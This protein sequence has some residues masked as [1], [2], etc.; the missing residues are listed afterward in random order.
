MATYRPE[1]MKKYL[2]L[3]QPDDAVFCTYVFIDGT[4]ENVRAKTRTLDFEPK[5]PEECPEWTFCALAS[6]QWPDAGPKSEAYLSP[7]ALFRDPFFK[8]RNK[9]VLCEVLQTDRSPNKT[10]TRRSCL[11]AMNKAKDQQPWFGIEQEYVVTEKDGHP[12]DWPRDVK[13]TI[14]PLGPYCFGVGADATSGRYISDAHYKACTYAGVKMAGTNCEGMLSQW[15]YQVGPLEGVDAADH[16][17][18]SRYILDR[19]AEDFGVLVTLDPMPYPPGDWLGSAMHTNFSTKAMRSDGG[20]SAIRTAIEKLKRNA[21]ADLAKYDT[22]RIKRNQLRV[23]SGVMATPLKQ[24][25]ADECSKE[26]SVRIP[27]AVVDAGKGY[28]EDRRPGANADPYTVCETII[29]TPDDV[30]FCTYVFIDGTLEN[31]RAKTRTL[32]F[33]PKTPEECPRWTFCALGTYQWGDASAKSEMY[34]E[35]VALF[36]DPFLKGRNKL[37]LCQ[38][39]KYDGTPHETNTRHSCVEVMT[40][41]DTQEPWFGIE[42]EYVL[43]GKDGLPLGWPRDGHSIRPLGPFYNSVGTENTVGRQISDAHLKAC[44]YAGVKI[45]GTNSEVVLSQWEYQV[46]PLKGT[47]AGDHLWISRYILQRVAE[48]FDV[49]ISFDPKPFES[50]ALCG[51]GGHINF[52]TKDMRKPGGLEHIKVALKKLEANAAEH[53]RDLRPAQ[54]RRG[55]PTPPRSWHAGDAQRE[56]RYLEDRRPGANVE[57]Y[58]A[59]AAIVKTVCL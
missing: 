56:L 36:R 48:E 12:V 53:L 52:S 19:V 5:T 10:N 34:L 15:E 23:G 40:K 27:R 37:V 31:V 17:W 32:D 43:R 13:H 39:L 45:S 14:K 8:G 57:P 58:S 28:L 3:E 25:T 24:F 38:V 51:S 21:D 18:M 22:A 2:E 54:G 9:L 16:L 49:V 47:A 26:V 59:T 42:Q 6:Y 41:A 46:G 44:A 20:I 30:V 29:R 35:P 55:K 11:N 1:I 4:L 33:E 7:V 50:D